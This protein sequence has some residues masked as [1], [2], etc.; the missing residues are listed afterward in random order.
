MRGIYREEAC[1]NNVLE[2]GGS[3]SPWVFHMSK[4]ASAK[5]FVL[6]PPAVF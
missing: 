5:I 3:V 6:K 4:S 1:D 2:N